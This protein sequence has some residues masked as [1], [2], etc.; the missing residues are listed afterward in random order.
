M[1]SAVAAGRQLVVKFVGAID[2][3]LGKAVDQVTGK[4]G[5]AGKSATSTGTKIRT[6]VAAGAVAAAAGAVKFGK[7]AVDAFKSAAGEVLP[8]KRNLGLSA[9]DASRL[10]YQLKMSGVD[11]AKAATG[12]TIFSKNLDKMAGADDTATAKAEASRDAIK[13]KIAALQQAGPHTKGYADKMADLKNKLDVVTISQKSSSSVLAQMGVDY[14]DAEGNVKPMADLMPQLAE[15]FSKMPDGPEKTAAAMKLFGKS[16]ASLLP[17][18]NKGAAGLA[19]LAA[20]SDQYGQTLTGSNLDALSKSKAAQR[21]WNTALEGLQIQFGAQLLPM[22]TRGTTFLTSKLIPA[23]TGVTGFLMANGD[24]VKWV[25][26][27]GGGLVGLITTISKVTKAW[28]VVQGVLNVVMSANPIGLVVIAIAALAA[29]LV[30]AYNNSKEFRRVVDTAF[31][32]IASAGRWLWNNA[33]QPVIQFIVGG[34]ATV[35]KGIAAFLTGLSN[36]PGFG[37]AKTAADQLK[38]MG[39]NAQAAADSIGKIPDEKTTTV[40]AVTAG[41]DK[42]AEI[43]TKIDLLTDKQVKASAVGDSSQV[44]ALQKKIDDLKGKKVK[45]EAE[46]KS[47]AI[48][49]KFRWAQGKGSSGKMSLIAVANGGVFGGVKPGLLA[50]RFANG[51]EN[52]VAQIAQAGAWRVWAEPETGGEG[53]VPL[54][55]SK[56]P[57]SVPIWWEIGRRLGVVRNEDGGVYGGQRSAGGSLDE[58]IAVLLQLAA[59]MMTRDDLQALLDASRQVAPGPRMA[60]RLG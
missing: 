20:K 9:E 45:V 2:P 39:D 31:N 15:K 34:F 57:R 12:L 43:Q 7:D 47:G 8:L 58:L 18:L 24:A 26:G 23:V 53:Y 1:P 60:V 41:Q 22:L 17:F 50:Q 33:L 54:A 6:A 32:A 49:G 13:A 19:E 51:A 52:H 11:S 5:G 25:V 27:V 55:A 42:V 59:R 37:W 38:G 30:Y 36:I 35:V 3:S 14:R 46:M 56:R 16:G 4:L 10:R 29:G 44:A 40:T 21:D 28:S 48:L